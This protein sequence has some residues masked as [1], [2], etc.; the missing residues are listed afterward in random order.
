MPTTKTGT[1]VYLSYDEMRAIRDAMLGRTWGEIE[2]E[3]LTQK[4]CEELDKKIEAAQNRILDKRTE[5]NQ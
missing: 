4:E 3:W 5:E 2:C 1:Q